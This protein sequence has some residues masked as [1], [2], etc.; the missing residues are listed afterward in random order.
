MVLITGSLVKGLQHRP[1]PV[2]FMTCF[3]GSKVRDY[4]PWSIVVRL[5]SKSV[6]MFDV[7]EVLWQFFNTRESQIGSTAV[8]FIIIDFALQ[9]FIFCST[10]LPLRIAMTFTTSWSSS[11]TSSEVL[12]LLVFNMTGAVV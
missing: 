7:F 10:A 5:A 1:R 12:G 6:N 4:C 2:F 3:V 9:V 11:F 8:L